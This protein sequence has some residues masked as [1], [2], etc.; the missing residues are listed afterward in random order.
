MRG[1]ALDSTTKAIAGS[2]SPHPTPIKGE[3]A[4]STPLSGLRIAVTRPAA[5]AAALIERI[6]AA[7][8]EALAL[9]LLE[10]APPGTPVTADELRAKAR[11]AD[12]IIFIS[13]NAV[14]M[15]VGILP[16]D[17][18]PPTARIAAIGKGTARALRA[19]GFGEV[20]IP[21]NGA[22]SEALLAL[23]EFAG[24]RDQTI[25]IVRGEGG[26]DLLANTLQARS[27][28]VEHALVY[29]RRPLPPDLPRLRAGGP[30]KFVL[31]SSEALRVLLDAAQTPDDIAWLR[32][33]RYV[34]GHPRIA[35][36][37][38]TKGLVHGII[39]ESPEDDALYSALVSLFAQEERSP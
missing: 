33:Q 10:I 30:T 24:V 9:P 1:Q 29:R 26:R 5:Q 31:T 14:R 39:V 36:L 2:P 12:S 18:W 37:G 4:D 3:G 27:A 22:D 28:T 20:L 8:G 7:G 6:R 32:D 13:P 15:A 38:R 25:L 21:D 19:A 17:D 11:A 23:P 35:A 16:P 34:F